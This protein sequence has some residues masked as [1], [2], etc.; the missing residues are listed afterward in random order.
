[1][2]HS[3]AK[4]YADLVIKEDLE[5][6]LSLLLREHNLVEVA[7][8]C[9][10]TRRT[11]YKLER[12][13]NPRFKTK[14]GIL[15]ASI[16]ENP[17]ETLDFLLKR[18][19]DKTVSVLMSYLSHLYSKT[20]NAKQNP[21][22]FAV[23]SRRFLEARKEHFGLISDEIDDEVNTM[24][25]FLDDIALELRIQLPPESIETTK[26]EHLLET[27]PYII[28]DVYFGEQT[29]PDLAKTYNVSPEWTKVISTTLGEIAIVEKV[30]TH[31]T[32]PGP[33]VTAT[34][35]PA[36]ESEFG[37]VGKA[38]ATLYLPS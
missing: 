8:K 26:P 5:H 22:A 7:R 30:K 13:A 17:S 21:R 35:A 4:K 29:P 27:I 6:F 16:E 14:I 3:I 31:E 15:K 33:L 2:S 32:K 34:N 24:L 23:A 19:K 36:E 10:L 20:I 28:R 11:I 38:A 1:M 9:R 12:T 18:S 37:L 25:R